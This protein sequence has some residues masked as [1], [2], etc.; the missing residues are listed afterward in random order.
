MDRLEE[1]K[2]KQ[3]CCFPGNFDGS[4]MRRSFKLAKNPDK[5]PKLSNSSSEKLIKCSSSGKHFIFDFNAYPFPF[6]GLVVYCYLSFYLGSR[7]IFIYPGGCDMFLFIMPFKKKKCFF[8]LLLL[9][10]SLDF[11]GNLEC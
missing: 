5:T 7:R 2:T 1:D 8:L 4:S 6:L 10:K 11:S 9:L 3:S